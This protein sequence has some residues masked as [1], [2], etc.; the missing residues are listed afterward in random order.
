MF[1]L[2][3]TLLQ[4]A[5]AIIVGCIACVILTKTNLLPNSPD[6]R[7]YGARTDVKTAIIALQDWIFIPRPGYSDVLLAYIISTASSAGCELL[8]M[9]VC[10]S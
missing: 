5:L 7:G 10:S 6:Q 1:V 2:C 4:Q 3:C 8:T 9:H